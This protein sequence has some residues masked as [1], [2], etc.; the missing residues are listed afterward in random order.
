[1][2][3]IFSVS[4]K[5]SQPL[6]HKTQKSKQS[7]LSLSHFVHVVFLGI[8]LL[9]LNI[10]GAQTSS[11]SCEPQ[12]F[13]FDGPPENTLCAQYGSIT[14]HISVGVGTGYINSS[15]LPLLPAN[16]RILVVGDFNVNTNLIWQGATIRINPGVAITV[17]TGIAGP[18]I[19][20]I[21]QLRSL[22]LFWFMERFNSGKQW[23][24]DQN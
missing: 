15:Q 23:D 22:C 4:F 16:P 11:E 17:G 7:V 3:N 12:P 9:F 13:E 21:R 19:P 10:A 8:F 20:H 1:M 2:E 18:A 24:F 14:F 5:I 6:F